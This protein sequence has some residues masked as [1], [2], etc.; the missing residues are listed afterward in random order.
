VEFDTGVKA[1]EEAK[2]GVVRGDWRVRGEGRRGVEVV[3][4][5]SGDWRAEG[6]GRS[7]SEK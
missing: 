6:S 2:T 1:G 4:G 5:A 7:H 3:G